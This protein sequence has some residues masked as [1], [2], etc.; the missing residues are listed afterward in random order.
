MTEP[1]E[2]LPS[3]VPLRQRPNRKLPDI[4]D[5]LIIG[6]GPGGTM[7]AF[8]AKELGLEA[9][10]IDYDDVLKR[11]R[12]YSKSKLILPTFGGGDQMRFPRGAEISNHLHFAPIDKDEMHV[13]WKRLYQE[14]AIP[15][16][17]G[18]ELTGL[19]RREDGV[20]QAKGWD[21]P[22]KSERLILCKHVVVAIGRGV[23][24]RFDIPGNTD[25]IAFRLTD[26]ASYVG[27]PSCVIGG[28]TS[29]AEAVIAISNAKAAAGDPSHVYWSYRGD[30]MPKVSKALAEIFFDAYLGNGNI[31]YNPRSEPVGVFPGED[32][33]DYLCIRTTRH[34]IP[35]R[36]AE[37]THFEFPKEH[38][39]ACIG[40]D[41]PEGFL[42]ALGIHMVTGGGEAGRK[43]MLVTPLLETEQPN[44]YLIGDILSQAYL[45]CDDFKADP[46]TW[47]EIK[48]RGNI[49]S[50]LRD[51]VLVAEVIAQ[52]LEG[53][54]VI[55]VVLDDAEEP[56]PAPEPRLVKTF[57]GVIES[58]GPPPA[59]GG[60]Q[61]PPPAGA[62]TAR[63]VRI[64]AGGVQENEFP[65]PASGIVTIGSTGSDLS[66]PDDSGLAPQHASIAAGPEGYFLRDDGGSTGV[67]FRARPG[68]AIPLENGSIVRAGRQ[69][70][71]VGENDVRHFNQKGQEIRR[72]AIGTRTLV[73]GREAP[74]VT[75]DS[76]DPT[77]SRRHL[78]LG[79][80][81]GV[82][83]LKDLKSVNGT[84]VKVRSA[85]KLE[86]G[87]EFRVGRQLFRFNLV[88]PASEQPVR[89]VTVLAKASPGG[90]AALAAATASRAAGAPA[91]A[92]FAP[93]AAP[94]VLPSSSAPVPTVTFQ[95]AGAPGAP[96]T[97]RSGQTVCELAE[98]KGIA[99]FAECHAGLC[100]SDPVRILSGAEH[101]NKLEDAESSTLEDLCRLKPG[102][103]R[104]ACML[105][106]K[107]PTVV[108]IVKRG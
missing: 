87:D 53:R 43:R 63:L 86:S 10:V 45:E 52:R 39:I 108:Q 47:R 36:P 1:A 91:L 46:S 90:S 18:V 54:A 95:G 80:K 104:L 75:L 55:D 62:A 67:F 42:N 23:P 69:F 13:S 16:E 59:S 8:R 100:G 96:F 5:V 51:G 85:V 29:A 14:H 6:G 11:I 40:E 58:Q 15:V 38:C 66:F 35:G 94:A 19:T 79:W 33:A 21:H 77:L 26:P 78:S 105:R 74:D 92:A 57:L 76:S 4:L 71:V 88:V 20:W 7:A 101:L 12:D 102:E 41:I 25:G 50:A 97:L 83:I 70:L 99:I 64:L 3:V 2:P 72:I 44:V 84:F 24:R 107:G 89:H 32:R 82:T 17:V 68:E 106:P 22:A 48:H 73:A 60:E 98:E 37:S 31:T 56:A 30:K 93:A 34:S 61:A 65:L 28:G 103:Y 81:D 9:M 27:K 49:K